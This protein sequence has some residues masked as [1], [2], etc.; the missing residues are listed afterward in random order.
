MKDVPA[1]G[2]IHRWNFAVQILVSLQNRLPLATLYSFLSS[3]SLSMSRYISRLR[4]KKKE[5][6]LLVVDDTS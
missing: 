1:S 5:K 6:K 2:Y 4:E 3:S